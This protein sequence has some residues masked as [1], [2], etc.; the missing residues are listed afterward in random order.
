MYNV[1]CPR[2]F[3]QHCIEK[4]IVLCR[5]NNIT[6]RQLSFWTGR[7][8]FRAN[9]TQISLTLHRKYPEPTLNKEKRLYGKIRFGVIR[10]KCRKVR[11]FILDIGF[12][13]KKFFMVMR[14]LGKCAALCYCVFSK[15]LL[16]LACFVFRKYL[17]KK[18]LLYTNG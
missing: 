13:F 15:K 11:F 16:L 1:C 18:E 17:Y 6:F 10:K 9:I 4:K 7:C 3:R 8:K 14:L 5:L 12:A 2:D